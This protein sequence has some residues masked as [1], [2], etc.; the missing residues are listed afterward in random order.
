MKCGYVRPIGLYDDIENQKKKLKEYTKDIYIE[1]H[2]ENK[3][4]N[5]LDSLLHKT[6]KENDELFITDICIL[7]DSTKQ[8]LEII[9]LCSKKGVHIFIINPNI[10]VSSAS[11][12]NFQKVLNEI[13]KFQNDVVRFRTQLCMNKAA[14]DVKKMGRPQRSDDNAKR[15]IEIYMSKEYTLDEIRETTNISKATLYTHLEK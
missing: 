7:A 10:L 6:L 5:Q 2:A 9:D 15:A 12:Y 8:L 3:R 13:S 11:E 14:R 1:E 4:R